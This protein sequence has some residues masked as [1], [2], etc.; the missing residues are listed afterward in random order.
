MRFA[1]LNKNLPNDVS[2]N[3]SLTKRLAYIA[4]NLIWWIPLVLA[5]AKII[6]YRTA[7]IALFVLTVMRAVVNLYRI[8][9]LNPEQA[10]FF[11]LRSA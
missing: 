3:Q 11:P 7:F 1:W 5:V 8:N 2:V 10:E 6:D 4:Y 9:V